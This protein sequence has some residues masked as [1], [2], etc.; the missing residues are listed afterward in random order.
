ME[1]M[2]LTL[3][4]RLAII[5]D[6]SGREVGS[7]EFNRLRHCLHCGGSV[8][9]VDCKIEW[10]YEQQWVV[11]PNAP[12]CNGSLIDLSFYGGPCVSCGKEGDPMLEERL[13]WECG[14]SGK[15]NNR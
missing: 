12:S 4:E 15:G 11:C 14:Q 8:L 13:C 10:L 7:P 5:V 1:L 6:H 3:D 9:L 2:E